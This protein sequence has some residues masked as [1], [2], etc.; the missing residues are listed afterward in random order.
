MSPNGLTEILATVSSLMY[1]VTIGLKIAIA[2]YSIK[3]FPSTASN[4]V[5]IGAFLFGLSFIGFHFIKYFL[6]FINN[7]ENMSTFYQV[8]GIIASFGQFLFLLGL[9]RLFQ[10]LYRQRKEVKKP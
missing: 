2:F 5:G 1:F 7:G 6:Y 8:N 4:I 10:E 9:F 3:H